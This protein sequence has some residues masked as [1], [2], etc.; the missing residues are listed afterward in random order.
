MIDHSMAVTKRMEKIKDADG[1]TRGQTFARLN[2]DFVLMCFKFSDRT[3]EDYVRKTIMGGF[4][5]AQRLGEKHQDKEIP[6]KEMEAIV[7]DVVGG[8]EITSGKP[9]AR[10]VMNTYDYFH[11]RSVDIYDKLESTETAGSA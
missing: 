2:I 6:K 8:L 11:S 3:L 10:E 5:E 9:L 7:R 4:I 1:R